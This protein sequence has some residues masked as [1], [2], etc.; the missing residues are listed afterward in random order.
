MKNKEFETKAIRHQVER[1][2]QNEHSVPIF[3]TSSY[4]FESA[5]HARALFAKEAEG[6]IYSRY[7]NPN[8]DEFIDKLCLLEGAEAGIST[9]SGM[10]AMFVSIASF[11]NQG[12]HIVCL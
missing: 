4:L 11:L 3:A 5:E 1:T 9:A 12:D 10:A 7:S 2:Q 8:N 6:N